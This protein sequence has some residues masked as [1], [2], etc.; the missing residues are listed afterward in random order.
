MRYDQIERF[1]NE[2]FL[3]GVQAL[4]ARDVDDMRWYFGLA[5]GFNC[6]LG[7]TDLANLCT[8]LL[9]RADLT[10][11]GVRAIRQKGF[12]TANYALELAESSK[13]V[14]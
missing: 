8:Q 9:Y 13:A 2:V 6:L 4:R 7:R 12:D 14:I 1:A 5:W 3:E 10:P 11:D